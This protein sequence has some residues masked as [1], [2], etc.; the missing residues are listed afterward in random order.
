MDIKKKRMAIFTGALNTTVLS[1]LVR[2]PQR[3][4]CENRVHIKDP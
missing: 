1:P 4:G 2:A 3:S